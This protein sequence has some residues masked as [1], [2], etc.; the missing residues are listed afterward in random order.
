MNTCYGPGKFTRRDSFNVCVVLIFSCTHC[1]MYIMY[2]NI[3]IL[4]NYKFSPKLSFCR[5][6]WLKQWFTRL[7][8]CVFSRPVENM[9]GRKHVWRKCCDCLLMYFISSGFVASYFEI[10][11]ISPW[12]CTMK[13]AE[14][15]LGYRIGF[16]L[17]IRL[18]WYHDA[19]Q[20][21][22]VSSGL[23]PEFVHNYINM[24]MKVAEASCVP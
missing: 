14:Q 7:W 15:T 3:F 21:F 22:S 8:P 10:L 1:H 19:D 6:L 13:L 12:T 24:H 16:K 4:E 5:R 17:T 18:Q 2:I 9:K 20:L 23:D 11:N